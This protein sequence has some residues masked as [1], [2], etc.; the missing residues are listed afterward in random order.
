MG[1]SMIHPSTRA[2]NAAFN[3]KAPYPKPSNCGTAIGGDS[4]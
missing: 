4:G 2:S 3:A 1:I